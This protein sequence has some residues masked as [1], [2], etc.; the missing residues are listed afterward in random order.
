MDEHRDEYKKLRLKYTQLVTDIN[1]ELTKIDDSMM[2]RHPKDCLFRINRDI[3]FSKDKSPYKP[4]FSA[5]FTDYGKKDIRPG[6][7][8]RID[9][10]G[11]LWVGG[12]WY[13]ITSEE[14]KNL[15]EKIVENWEEFE[16][17]FEDKKMIKAFDGGLQSEH[18][19]K[20]TPT[21]FEA[22]QPYS[23]YLK[24]KEFFFMSR[25]SI[26]DKN[27]SD[28]TKIIIKKYKLISPIID[29]L[30]PENI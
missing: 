30:R 9:R 20:R 16:A 8:L 28:L 21:G 15:R 25:Q 6:Y 23:E 14:M 22:D 17:L 29:W 7:Y 2:L 11:E 1:S 18:I 12:G 19:L 10:N 4:H 26:V 24:Y 3:R 27:Y 5:A 13:S